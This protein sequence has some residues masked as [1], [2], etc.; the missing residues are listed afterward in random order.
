[1]LLHHGCRDP[2]PTFVELSV[3]TAGN[4]NGI[5]LLREMKASSPEFARY[6]WWYVA[7]PAEEGG[8]E[9]IVFLH[10]VAADT[11]DQHESGLTA[12]IM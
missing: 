6:Q 7:G 2:E 3:P 11:V 5:R 9:K 8:R 4:L 12:I 1:V 10:L